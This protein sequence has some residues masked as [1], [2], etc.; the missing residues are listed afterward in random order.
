MISQKIISISFTFYFRFFD[1]FGLKRHM[2]SI[3]TNTGP[4]ICIICNKIT[5]TAEALKSHQKY[6][7]LDERKFECQECGKAFKKHISLKEHLMTH[8][9]FGNVGLY[10]CPYCSRTFNSNANMY[11]H[12]KKVHPVENEKM[13]QEKRNEKLPQIVQTMDGIN[14]TNLG[15]P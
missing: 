8:I 9:G 2:R 3:H 14:E 15:N 5:P 11:S 1:E 4:H 12:R 6:S 7:H 10:N 13:L